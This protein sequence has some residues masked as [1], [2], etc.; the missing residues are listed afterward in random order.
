VTRGP[1]LC[2]PGGRLSRVVCSLLVPGRASLLVSTCSSSSAGI[3]STGTMQRLLSALS[4]SK[5]RILGQAL[6][7]ALSGGE[8]DYTSGH[9]GWAVLILSVPMI[10]EM[11]LQSVFELADIFFVSRLGAEAVAAVGIVASLLVIVFA[12]GVGLT[13]AVTAMVARRIGEKES[14]AASATAFQGIVVAVLISAPLAIGG[15]VFTE[16]LMRLMGASDAVVELGATY[17]VI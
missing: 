6:R 16:D 3:P 4:T 7:S 17:G 1:D 2:S 5:L 15:I 14:R 11:L 13:M 10:L 12:I 8:R 9:L